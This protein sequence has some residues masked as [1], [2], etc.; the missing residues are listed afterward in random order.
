MEIVGAAQSGEVVGFD[1]ESEVRLGVEPGDLPNA[2][3][4]WPVAE[5]AV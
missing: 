4:G 1:L 3:E 2:G 5:G